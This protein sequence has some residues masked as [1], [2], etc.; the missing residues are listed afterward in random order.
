MDDRSV[1]ITVARDG[2]PVT[3]ARPITQV[4]LGFTVGKQTALPM[5]ALMICVVNAGA[6]FASVIG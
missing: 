5:T 4:S 3:S 2:G 1:E 6:V